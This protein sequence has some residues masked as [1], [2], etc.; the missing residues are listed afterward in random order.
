MTDRFI[1]RPRLGLT[2]P[3]QFAVL[4]LLAGAAHAQST[5][6]A[7]PA[8][9]ADTS[10]TATATAASPDAKDNKALPQVV[11]TA[12]KRATSLQ[13][14]PIAVTALSASTIEDNHVKS[15]L[16]VFNLVPSMQGTG[17][18]DHGIVSITL[19]GIGND[20]AKTEYADPEVALFVDGVFAPRPEHP[21]V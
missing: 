5:E 4:A 7:A 18:G 9:Q 1:R 14:T 19:R 17:Q 21:E 12:T 20:S 11:V 10:A 15:M 13:K 6:G 8:P 16:D 2:T 3:V